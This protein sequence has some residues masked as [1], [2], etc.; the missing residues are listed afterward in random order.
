[1]RRMALALLLLGATSLAAGAV[2]AQ[3][4]SDRAQQ[5][6]P[7]ILELYKI[8]HRAPELA[9]LEKNTSALLAKELAAAGFTVVTGIGKYENHPEWKGY[10]VAA[11]LKNG[12][13][14]VVLLRT[15]MDALP[16]S[17]RTGLTYA[18]KIPGV[19]H[20]CGHDIHIAA[21][22]GTARLL[23]ADK[24][25]WRG[26]V[27]MIGQPAEETLEGAKALIDD[28]LF[29]KLPL[30]DYSLAI[31][32]TG[33]LATGTVGLASGPALMSVQ[34][35]RITVR[36]QGG[37]AAT[38][39]QSRDPV[40]LAAAII[41]GF[42]TIV[43]RESSEFS[44]NVVAVTGILAGDPPDNPKSNIIPSEVKIVASVS[45]EDDANRD[46]DMK[47]IERIAKYT[48][49]AAGFPDSLAPIVEPSE[50]EKISAVYNDPALVQRLTGTFT[51]ELG[52]KNVLALK[53]QASADD[54]YRFENINGKAIPS[55]F[56]MV[57]A[58][59]PAVLAEDKRTGTLVINNHDPRFAPV[60]DST[61]KASIVAETSAVLSL[62]SS[63]PAAK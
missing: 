39:D 55:V 54:F 43:S 4:L 41:V 59:D 48:A 31:H 30:P 42:Q 6:L 57:G 38:P 8:I 32:D 5:E 46:R 60:P 7:A 36:G 40:A 51:S 47:S 53:Q 2:R 27:I 56:I 52:A 15:E 45:A 33:L 23:S 20:T 16:L 11:V 24:A 49:L 22:I 21:M 18:S 12:D 63:K 1:M 34:A 29:N 28:G 62:L 35:V 10:G 3:S 14:P 58:S 26:T 61:L 25:A 17:E 44:P 13:G 19:S 37:Q 50:S 9:H